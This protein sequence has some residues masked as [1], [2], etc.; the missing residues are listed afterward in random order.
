M[1]RFSDRTI[2]QIKSRIT[3]SDLMQNYAFVEN[4]GGSKWV[5]CPFHGGGN[6]RTASCKI[7]DER[8]T[9]YCFGCHESGDIFKL[10][11]KKEGVDF[12]TSVEMLAKK[13]GVEVEE[14]SSPYNKEASRLIREEK[15]TL[16][17]LYSR[18]TNTFHHLLLNSDEAKGARNYLKKRNVSDE[19]VEKFCLGYAPQNPSW[20]H[21][22]LVKK[23]YSPEFLATS[24]LFSQ[25]RAMWPLFSNRL[26]FPIRDRQGRTIAFSGRDLSGDDRA[27]KYINSPET[28]IYQKKETYFGLYEAKNTIANGEYG[29]ILC[30][31]N[32]DVVAM[33]QAGYTSA[34]A[35]LGTSFT[36]EQCENIRKWYPKNTVFNILFDNDEAGQKSTERAL[37]IM[38]RNGFEQRVHRLTTAKDASELLENS[39]PEGVT[40]EFEPYVSG[41]DYLVQKNLTRYD[42]KTAVGKV[43]LVNSLSEYLAGC[44]SEVERDSYILS[45]SSLLGVSDETIKEDLNKTRN[46]RN[47]MEGEVP[48]GAFQKERTRSIS[49]ELYAMLY[50][51][52]HRS[53]FRTYRSRISFGDLEDRDAQMLYMAIENAMRD[54]TE[55]NELFLTYLD[56]PGLKDMVSTTFALDEYSKAPVGALDEAIDRIRLKSM[57]R[58]RD[59]LTNQLK[60]SSSLDE[61]EMQDLLERKMKLDGQI[62]ELRDNLLSVKRYDSEE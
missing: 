33:H 62:N 20:L 55:S 14:S 26:M 9:Y 41:F 31:G 27:P 1:P 18:L 24:G 47:K 57:E 61:D 46:T 52:N 22:F 39:G 8:G 11:M 58:K 49:I 12:T 13:A 16:F 5:K 2:D 30:E 3:I 29:P 10:F 35:S 38:N 43:A 7:D 17:D 44:R 51:A 23:G 28:K 21:S 34:L 42:I 60:L 15:D 59:V 45:L 37:V 50:L 48:E 40:N 56:D 53:L 6:E 36:T 19:M 54:G 25:R 32:F 4:R